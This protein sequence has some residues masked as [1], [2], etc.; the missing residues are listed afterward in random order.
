[1][2]DTWHNQRKIP[3]SPLYSLWLDDRYDIF[4]GNFRSWERTDWKA[5]STVG[6]HGLVTNDES[7]R[8]SRW[9]RGI[10]GSNQE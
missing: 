7:W 1:M 8:G 5:L 3:Q 10:H 6:H 2:K 4:G 9:R